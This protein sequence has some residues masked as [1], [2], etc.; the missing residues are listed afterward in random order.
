MPAHY[1]IITLELILMFSELKQKITFV[2]KY[3][4]SGL[5]RVPLKLWVI[6]LVLILIIIYVICFIVPK[7]IDFTY[8][9]SRYCISKLTILPDLYKQSSETKFKLQS[10][11]LT[12]IGN[13][14]LV[15]NKICFKPVVSPAGEN[16]NISYSLFGGPIFQ[17]NYIIDV[18]SRPK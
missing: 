17:S 1:V 3:V 4:K 18:G 8:A 12:K 16:I 9:E 14:N 5:L 13:L 15:S 7:N 11:G 10:E 2:L 6:P